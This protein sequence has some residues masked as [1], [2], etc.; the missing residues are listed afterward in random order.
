MKKQSY[1]WWMCVLVTSIALAACGGNNTDD[2]SMT[3]MPATENTQT[4][5]NLAV[6]DVEL[7][8]TIG[9]DRAITNSTDDFAPTDT[10]FASVETRGTGSGTTLTARWTFEDGQVIDE[11][12]QTISPMG[13]ANTE[14]HIS[15]PGGLPAGEYS[16]EILLNGQSVETESFEVS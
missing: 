5:E 7:G 13:P 6:V 4:S 9:P 12:S 1:A 10:V 3:D 8:R 2:R 11:T 15:M 16:V 14:F